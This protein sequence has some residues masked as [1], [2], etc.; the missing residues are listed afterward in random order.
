MKWFKHMTDASRDER[1]V[2]LRDEGGFEAYG[3]YWFLLETVAEKMDKSTKS[4]VE[5]PINHWRR[6]TGFSS[7]KF[8]KLAELCQSYGLLSVKTNGT[9]VEI[10][11][12]NLLK[13]R[14]NHTK[15][16]QV[17]SKQEVEVDKEVDNYTARA[18]EEESKSDFGRVFEKGVEIY[19]MLTVKNNSP[20]HQWISDGCD[21]DL[22]IIPQLERFKDRENIMSWSFFT[23]AIADAKATRL[24]PMPKGEPKNEPIK[25]AD[26]RDVARESIRQAAINRGL[27]AG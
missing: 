1:L 18:R 11:I 10:N 14:D 2:H 27:I 9:S 23:Q 17:T 24:K 21:V 3:F 6:V 7:K 13:V 19:P 26:S 8:Y 16:L 15:N 12:P 25:K 20:I 22:D 4:S 5:F